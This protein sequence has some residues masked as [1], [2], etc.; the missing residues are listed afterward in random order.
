MRRLFPP[1]Q[2]DKVFLRMRQLGAGE[3]GSLVCR[4]QSS[5]GRAQGHPSF[6]GALAQHS[7]LGSQGP[8]TRDHRGKLQ[9]S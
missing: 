5:G 7:Q 8:G 6:L 3:P 2:V 9:A 4:G 1:M